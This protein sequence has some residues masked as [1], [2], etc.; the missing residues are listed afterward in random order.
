MPPVQPLSEVATS[1][2]G[3][4]GVQDMETDADAEG[5][6]EGDEGQDEV[7]AP[8]KRGRPPKKETSTSTAGGQKRRA[9]ETKS[10]GTFILSF[11]SIFWCD[12]IADGI[13]QATKRKK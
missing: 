13:R 5:D 7:A 3:D 6:A 10:T 4:K 8:K 12:N 9:P 11:S 2:A 1:F